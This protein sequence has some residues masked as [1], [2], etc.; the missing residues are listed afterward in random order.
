MQFCCFFSASWYHDP[1]VSIPSQQTELLQRTCSKAFCRWWIMQLVPSLAGGEAQWNPPRFALVG[2]ESPP[3]VMWVQRTPLLGL[4]FR[5]KQVWWERK[6]K[7]KKRGGAIHTTTAINCVPPFLPGGLWWPAELP[8]CWWQ[9][10][11]AWYHQLW[12]CFWLQLLPQAFC[13]HL[14]LCLQ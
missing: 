7:K 6:L 11:S 9:V 3:V 4:G 13:L 5:H 2:M 10:G 14:G 12:L 8:R 1:F